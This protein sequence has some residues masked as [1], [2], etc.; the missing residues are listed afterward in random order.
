MNL[1]NVPTVYANRSCRAIKKQV[2][3]PNTFRTFYYSKEIKWLVKPCAL[4]S[5]PGLKTNDTIKNKNNTTVL[6]DHNWVR[7]VIEIQLTCLTEWTQSPILLFTKTPKMNKSI[8][9]SP[10]PS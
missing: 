10:T 9:T 5:A 7:L 2:W 8:D 3:S 4:H 1:S 6:H